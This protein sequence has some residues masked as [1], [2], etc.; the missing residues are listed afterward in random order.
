MARHGRIA[1][2][3]AK[4]T[5]DIVL[6]DTHSPDAGRRRELRRRQLRALTS[7]SIPASVLPVA[8]RRDQ[9]PAGNDGAELKAA[10]AERERQGLSSHNEWVT[11]HQKFAI[12]FACVVFG[13]IGLALGATHRRDGALGSFVLGLSSSSRTTFRS[14]SGRRLVKGDIIPPW[15]AAWLPNIVL[16]GLAAALFVW[17]ERVADQPIRLPVAIQQR[18]SKPPE[19][20][21]PRPARR[22][23][24]ILDRYVGGMYVADPAVVCGVA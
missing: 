9:G 20:G 19:S 6:E 17:R 5:V 22:C 8:E 16:G 13:V 1:I 11:I 21:D 3:R 14:T 12:P 24:R 4:H 23:L 15:L 7:A 18:L 2:N 10:A